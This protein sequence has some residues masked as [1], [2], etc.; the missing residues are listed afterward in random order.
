MHAIAA[1]VAVWLM[2]VGGVE[3]PTC[4]APVGRAALMI[5]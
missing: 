3:P 5:S 4:C 2:A 1:G